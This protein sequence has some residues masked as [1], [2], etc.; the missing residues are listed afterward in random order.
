MSIADVVDVI[1]SIN[2]DSPADGALTRLEEQFE[3]AGREWREKLDVEFK[4]ETW[5]TT[6]AGVKGLVKFVQ[7][8][9]GKKAD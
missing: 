3:Q 8:S 7:K 6:D 5:G 1:H 4:R 9:R 2:A